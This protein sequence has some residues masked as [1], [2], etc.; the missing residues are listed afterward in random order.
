[1]LTLVKDQLCPCQDVDPNAGSRKPGVKHSF[2]AEL[3]QK[4]RTA[5]EQETQPVKT[6]LRV[7]NL[8]SVKGKLS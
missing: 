8:M 7:T 6:Q 4:Y 5:A 2:N 1:M 3:V